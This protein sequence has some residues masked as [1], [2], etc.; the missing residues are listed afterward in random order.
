MTANAATEDRRGVVTK[1]S[2]RAGIFF[3]IAA[4]FVFSISNALI[5]WLVARYPLGEV[6]FFRSVFSLLPPLPLRRPWLPRAARCKWRSAETPR[7]PACR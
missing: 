5:K 3:S 4:V 7:R 2:I 6:V 1:D